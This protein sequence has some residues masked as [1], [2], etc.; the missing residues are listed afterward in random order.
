MDSN[1]LTPSTSTITRDLDKL[2]AETGNIYETVL[3]ISK[4]SN[5]ISSEVKEELNHKLE[6]FASFT[7]NLE[8]VFENREQ[9]EISRYYERLPK[10]TLIAIKEFSNNEIYHRNPN[11]E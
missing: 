2:D 4:R 11:E 8:E 9:I 6:E 10:P 7:D 5:Q 3:I 1:E